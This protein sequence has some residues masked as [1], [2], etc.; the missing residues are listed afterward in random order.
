[1]P[2]TFNDIKIEANL[3][4]Y[5]KNTLA[6]IL[7]E[8]GKANS[9]ATLTPVLAPN[10]KTDGTT[11]VYTVHRRKINNV[12]DVANP[13]TGATA[14]SLAVLDSFDT[15]DWDSTQVATGKLRSIGFKETFNDNFDFSNSPKHAKDMVYKVGAIAKQRKKDLLKLLTDAATATAAALPAFA[16]GDT[17]VW[18]AIADLALKVQKVEDDFM[19]IADKE[20]I[21]V[22]ISDTVAKELAKEMGIV[23]NQEN[24]IAQTGFKSGFGINGFP[25]I[26]EPRF[27]GREVLVFN[28]GALVFKRE[29]ARKDIS[30][31]LGLTKFTGEIFYDVMKVIDT[32]RVF[33]FK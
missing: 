16:A 21:V 33:K 7:V 29:P 20:D 27:L 24:A 10:G 8:L 13:N 14:D 11:S 17:K 22:V 23:F 3:K 1:M 26:V 32:A 4:V 18:D 6:N 25:V 15:I 2:K 19:D 30:I 12:K 28:A 5:S 9:M 31:D